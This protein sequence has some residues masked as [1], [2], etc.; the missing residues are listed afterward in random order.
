MIS[1]FTFNIPIEQ[2]VAG[3]GSTTV[4]YTY[5][6]PETMDFALCGDGDIFE[7]GIEYEP[8]PPYSKLTLNVGIA[9]HLPIMY[10]YNDTVNDDLEWV[11]VHKDVTM[12]NGDVYHEVTN[13]N[14]NDHFDCRFNP[15]KKWFYFE[16]IVIPQNNIHAQKAEDR[17]EFIAPYKEETYK[18][19]TTAVKNDIQTYIDALDVF[20]AANGPMKH[21][22]YINKPKVGTMPTLPQS[23]KD[24]IDQLPNNHNL[25]INTLELE[26]GF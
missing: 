3:I 17:K 26:E 24:A 12:D 15:A 5:D 22:K 20:I 21:W 8:E 25:H 13:P 18:T 11:N 16:Q 9:S 1:T 10:Y 19:F 2:Y 14:M 23:V 4:S 6:G 7:A